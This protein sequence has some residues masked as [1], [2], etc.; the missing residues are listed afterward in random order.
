MSA[1]TIERIAIAE[2]GFAEFER[3][4]LVTDLV[5]EASERLNGAMENEF[6]YEYRD[7]D[8]YFQ[9]QSLR[10]I[11]ERGI[12]D[13][14]LIV[15]SKPQFMIELLRRH[16]ELQQFEQQL[17]LMQNVDWSNPLVLVHIS[18]TPDAVLSG[19]TDLNAY[20]VQRKKIM[21]R[22]SEPTAGG[23]Q[24][25]SLSLDSGDRVALRAV[26][27]FFGA[28]IPDDATSED[29]LAMH[30]IAEK[31][32][33]SH[34]RPAKV[35]RERYDKAMAMQY[36]GVWYA[37]R[38]DSEI[39]TTMQRIL[40]YPEL[41]SQHVSEIQSIKNTQGAA[42]RFTPEYE[43]AT[44]NFLAA[45]DQAEKLGV[46]VGSIGDAGDLAR[47][48][49]VEYAK[50]D[51]PTALTAE[52]AL[53]Q[54]EIGGHKWVNCPFCKHRQFIDPCASHIVCE[55]DECKAEV[56]DGRLV[57]AGKMNQKN[58]ADSTVTREAA[59]YSGK[60]NDTPNNYTLYSNSL[61]RIAAI[62]MVYGVGAEEV[63]QTTFGDE[64]RYIRDRTTREFIAWSS[65]LETASA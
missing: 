30:F 65:D 1:L 47:A 20:D 23:I 48:A 29:I 52:Q 46:V 53:E 57:F 11:F 62:R 9:G 43:R 58:S 59:S 51:C 3:E 56:R 24:V 63:R 25:T 34:E 6:M 45:I 13:T 14:E 7:N 41:I 37:G 4:R 28:D 54:Q 39:Q 64:L 22:I 60:T 12:R 16:I 19:E 40:Q 44:Y 36:G 2:R 50:S 32:Q 55:N 33:F 10:D 5:T 15:H 21:V 35:L 31:S 42:F 26:G 8:F 27:D 38:Q 17:E 18:P 49:G 61:E